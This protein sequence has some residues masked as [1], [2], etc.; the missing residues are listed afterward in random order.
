MQVLKFTMCFN[1]VFLDVSK[2]QMA[3]RYFIFK[4][5]M[6]IKY[7]EIDIGL[8]MDCESRPF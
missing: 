5:T 3:V 2:L 8:K 4:V 7:P 6:V 1:A